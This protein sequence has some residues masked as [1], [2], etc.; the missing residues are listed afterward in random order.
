MNGPAKILVVDDHADSASMLGLLLRRDGYNARVAT[1]YRSALDAAA[2]E[3]FDLLLSDI[4]LRDG[5]G[6][7]LLKEMRGLYPIPGIAVSAHGAEAD[8]KRCLAAGF[9]RHIL[10]PFLY[11]AM[12]V[13][14][15]QVLADSIAAPTL[16]D[17]MGDPLRG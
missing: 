14:I 9:Q 6:C 7:D 3:R 13:L 2:K 5:D 11:D 16:S 12:R 17:P 10:K 1:G 15:V 8:V 4:E